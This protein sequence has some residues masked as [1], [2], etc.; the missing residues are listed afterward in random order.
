VP[1][2]DDEANADQHLDAVI[3]LLEQLRTWQH[4]PDPA[5][6]I[7][8][9]AAAAT[10]N[11]E[12][13]PCWVL[14]V[15]PPSSGKTETVRT[16]DDIADARLNEVTSAGLLSWS[17]GKAKTVKPTGILARIGKQALVTFGDLSSLL[18]TSDRGGRD[19]VFGLLRRA[20]DG[21]VT[22]DIAPPNGADRDQQLRWSGRLTVVACVTGAIDRYATHADQLGPPLAASADSRTLHRGETP[23]IPSCAPQRPLHPSGHGTQS[24]LRT[25]QPATRAAARPARRYRRP[26]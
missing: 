18:P 24:S 22:R 25:T 12:G 15:A 8:A 4:L 16:L 20:Y 26:D 14:L 17:N 3:K 11:S 2:A 21:D 6:V 7:V 10:R 9:L 1:V 19:Q 23:S 5:H 13:E